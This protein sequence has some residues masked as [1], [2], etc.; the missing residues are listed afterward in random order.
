MTTLHVPAPALVLKGWLTT[1]I[2]GVDIGQGIKEPW[3]SWQA[4]YSVILSA[5]DTPPD[6]YTPLRSCEVQVDL[7]GKPDDS[8]RPSTIPW[9]MLISVGE[10]IRD[11]TCPFLQAGMTV[12]VGGAAYLTARLTDVMVTQSPI[13]HVKPEPS[14]LG[15][16]RM[17]LQVTYMANY[18]D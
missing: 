10:H 2:P 9:N 17:R 18:E 12:N 14:G 5:L 4:D 15:R 7:F 3:S 11:A 6:P 8:G 16:A 13:R 1:I